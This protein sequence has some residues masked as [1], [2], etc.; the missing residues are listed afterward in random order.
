MLSNYLI[1]IP[2]RAGSKGIPGKNTKRLNGKP[3]IQYSIEYARH[4]TN[5]ENICV[6]TNDVNVLEIADTL[7]LKVPFT[8]PDEL[9]GDSATA[10]DVIK[11]AIKFY[12]ERGVDYRAI[13]YLQ[14]TS[15]FR[16]YCHLKEAI[17]EFE[18]GEADMVVSVCESHLNPYFSLFEENE[19]GYLKRSK[20]LPQGINRRQDAP[21]VFQYNGSIYIV[22]VEALLKSELHRLTNIRKYQM[23]S[24]Y[25]IDI[26]V[27][28]DWKYAEFLISQNIIETGS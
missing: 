21:K 5:D 2:A 15:P 7:K 17:K 22:S 25:A 9:C 19:N 14:P 27:P 13:I 8:R 3:L 26:D 24:I 1:I 4:F 28:L 10:N 23:E 16:L 18:A 11:H 12:Q 6:S 20:E